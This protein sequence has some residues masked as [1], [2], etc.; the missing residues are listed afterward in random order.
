MST[1]PVSLREARY[2]RDNFNQ[3]HDVYRAETILR[4]NRAGVSLRLLGRFLHCSEGLVRHLKIVALFP[5][6]WKN[7]LLDGRYSTRRLVAEWR[8]QKRVK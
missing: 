1:N 4:L 2:L 8:R 7:L 3:L 6:Q 5:P